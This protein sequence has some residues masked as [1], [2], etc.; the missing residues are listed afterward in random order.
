MERIIV[1]R[2]RVLTSELLRRTLLG[3]PNIEIIWAAGV[4]QIAHTL[5]AIRQRRE[6]AGKS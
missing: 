6:P 2:G 1:R 3:D 4:R 5:R